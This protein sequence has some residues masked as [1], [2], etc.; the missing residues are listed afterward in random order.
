MTDDPKFFS[1][2]SSQNHS[3]YLCLNQILSWTVL[4]YFLDMF[5]FLLIFRLM[6]FIKNHLTKKIIWKKLLKNVL[7]YYFLKLLFQFINCKTIS[8]CLFFAR[9]CVLLQ[10]VSKLMEQIINDV[11]INN[12]ERRPD[13]KTVTSTMSVGLICKKFWS[14]LSH[15]QY[16]HKS[17]LNKVKLNIFISFINY[18]QC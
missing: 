14:K 1:I 8:S 13:S 4:D 15:F 18:N 12:S 6:V 17:V 7:Y 9:F 11:E 10:G 2:F 3:W 5:N 16:A